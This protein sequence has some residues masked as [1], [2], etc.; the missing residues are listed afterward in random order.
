ML[1][2]VLVIGALFVAAPHVYESLHAPRTF[3]DHYV[4]GELRMLRHARR[5]ADGEL[6]NHG[7]YTLY[8]QSGQQ[9]MVGE[10]ENGVRVG[11]WR[12]FYPDGRPKAQC[13]YVAG[14]GGYTAWTEDGAL[15]MQ[16]QLDDA[17]RTGAWTE[18]FP[19]G[20]K[21]IEGEYVE[22][23]QHGWW[24][25]WREGEPQPAMRILWENGRRVEG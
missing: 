17:K 14:R 10:Y 9:E 5:A 21:A 1:W 18:Y 4:T 15:L 11:P 2:I 16:G 23:R 24:T 25:Y 20:Q 3:G 6:V 12:W 19:S 22:D 7:T 13:R 8:Y